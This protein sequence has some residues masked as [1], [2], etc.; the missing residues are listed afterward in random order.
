MINIYTKMNMIKINK[1][2]T[3]YLVSLHVI[4]ALINIDSILSLSKLITAMLLTKNQ[5]LVIYSVIAL[6]YILINIEHKGN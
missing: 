6:G 4:F 5:D 3:N 2:E 1:K